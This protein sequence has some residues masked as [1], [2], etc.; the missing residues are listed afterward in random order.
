MRGLTQASDMK[1]QSWQD[2]HPDI[3]EKM[4]NERCQIQENLWLVI[5]REKLKMT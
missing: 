5:A 2:T 3:N 4:V 1:R